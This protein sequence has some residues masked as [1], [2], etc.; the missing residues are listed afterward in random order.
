MSTRTLQLNEGGADRVVRVVLGIALLSLAL[1]GPRTPW[2]LIGL[3]PLITGLAGF[4]PL[5]RVLGLSTCARGT[6]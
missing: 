3:L 4:C 5:Y 2:G 6:R 1:A